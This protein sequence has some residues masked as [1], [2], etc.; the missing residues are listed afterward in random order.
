M[1]PLED[2]DRRTPTMRE[3]GGGLV[4]EEVDV[5]EE[6]DEGQEDLMVGGEEDAL[7]GIRVTLSAPRIFNFFRQS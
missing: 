4:P 7:W 1:F 6:D 2:Y 3:D 5:C